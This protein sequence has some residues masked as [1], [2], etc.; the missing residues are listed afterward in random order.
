LPTLASPQPGQPLILYVLAT[1]TTVSRALV[2]EREASKEGRKLSHQVPIYFVSEALASSKKYYS[3]MEKICYAVVMSARKLRHYFKA[4]RVRVQTN[5]ALNDI[6]GNHDSSGRIG[7][8]AMELSEHV[9]DFEKR[10]AIKSQVLVD[11]I[12]YWMEPSC[13]TEGTVVETLWQV[14]CNRAWGVFGAG[15]TAVLKSPSGIRLRYAARLQFT[16]DADKCSNNIAEYEVVLLGLCM[17]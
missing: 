11:F 3:E 16:T 8:W 15:A 10:S 12:V 5:Q 2:Q 17:L 4:R 1:H 6:F 9:I 14:Q 13:Y 7:K